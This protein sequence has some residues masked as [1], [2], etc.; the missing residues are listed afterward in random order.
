[1]QHS[2]FTRVSYSS[3]KTPVSYIH[4]F[5]NVADW[6]Q[7]QRPTKMPLYAHPIYLYILRFLCIL[8]GK[9]IEDRVMD[10]NTNFSF[11]TSF[12]PLLELK[13]EALKV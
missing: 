7:N 6:Q 12:I 2:S 9:T 5:L 10:I 11:L 13:I 4:T 8:T 3:K 1:M